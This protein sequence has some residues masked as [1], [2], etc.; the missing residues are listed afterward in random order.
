[1]TSL[2]DPP[3]SDRP[4]IVYHADCA[5]GFAAAWAAWRGLGCRGDV[6]LCPA[7]YRQPPP[8]VTGR[9]VY[10]VDFSYPRDV[11]LGMHAQAKSLLVLDHHATAAKALE[12]LPFCVFDQGRSGAGL[13][14]DVLAAPRQGRR[15]KLIDYVE[16]RDLWRWELPNSREV[17]AFLGTLPHALS[18]FT[19]AAANL[20]DAVGEAFTV[21]K[22]TAVLQAQARYIDR[23]VACARWR[24]LEVPEG[25]PGATPRSG[26]AVGARECFAADVPVVNAGPWCVSEVLERLKNDHPA[27]PFVAAWYERPDGR[28]YYSLRSNAEGADVGTIAQFHGG[29][30]HRHAAG[31]DTPGVR[32]DL[33][34]SEK[35]P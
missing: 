25:T 18:A 31:F 11:L 12:G 19:E 3:P 15:P 21:L 5:D 29:G 20:D 23:T 33:R 9:E 7:V 2:P 22:G 1:M 4:L 24:A 8:D 14:W 35:R 13:A 28:L 30:G 32:T 17:S 6:D 26:F 34:P 27:A 10:V 16:D